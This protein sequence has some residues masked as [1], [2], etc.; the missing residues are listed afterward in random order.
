M[1]KNSKPT[2]GVQPK[3]RI[4][5]YFRRQEHQGHVQPNPR[6]APKLKENP[7]DRNNPV[8]GNCRLSN[9]LFMNKLANSLS[10]EY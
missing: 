6:I 7:V 3:P 4:H 9:H 1:S 5:Q 10:P 8:Q 2:D